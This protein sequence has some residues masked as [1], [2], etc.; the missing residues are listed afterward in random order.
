MGSFTGEV[1]PGRVP[2]DEQSLADGAPR[3]QACVFFAN[4]PF[5]IDEVLAGSLPEQYRKTVKLEYMVHPERQA[6]LPEAAPTDQRIVLFI[7]SKYLRRAGIQ[8]VYYEVGVGK[9]TFREIDGRVVPLALPDDPTA[10]RLEGMPFDQFIDLV[11]RVPILN[12][13][14]EG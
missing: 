13:M 2:C 9:G 4:L 10:G 3:E 7:G 5:R 14:P 6:L 12:L 8:D 11:R 1:E